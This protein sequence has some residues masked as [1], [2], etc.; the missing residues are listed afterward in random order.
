MK[1]SILLLGS[2]FCASFGAPVSAQST[3]FKIAP[4]VAGTF[5][6]QINLTF[7]SVDD[8]TQSYSD[9]VD[10]SNSTSRLGFRIESTMDGN[11]FMFNFETGLGFKNTSETSQA[12]TLDWFDW[13][14]TDIRKFEISYSGSFGKFWLGQGSMATDGA[15]EIDNSGTSIVGYVNLADT[16]GSY[17]FRHAGVL[18]DISIGDTFKDLDGGRRFRLRY[19]TPSLSG[20]TVS[21]AYGEEVLNENDDSEYYDTA[22][23]YK[24]DDSTFGFDAAIGYSWKYFD[25]ETT[26]YLV[27]SGTV[28]HKPSG[29][30]LT[31]AAGNNQNGDG[32]Y[33][34]AK[35]GWQGD[36][37]RQGSTAI[38]VDYYDGADFELAGSSSE[39]WGI[40]AVQ[41][42][43]D[44]NLEAYLGYRVYAYNDS[45]ASYQDLDALLVGARW[46]F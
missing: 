22:L 11:D 6:G 15:A 42:F 7:Q 25:G 37:I 31:L 26:E 28:M 30:N 20:V 33:W 19:D 8:G 13:Q 43:D 1:K 17:L 32:N 39:S 12:D 9:F 29:A 36:L 2:V 10:N 35:L 24:Y 21:I 4:G 44:L 3:E 16:A 34:Y 46:K 23:R 38:S 41:R 5:Y 45:I 27:T 40:Q 18:S 14:D